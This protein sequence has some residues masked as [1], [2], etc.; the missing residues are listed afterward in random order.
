MIGLLGTVVGMIQAFSRI[1]MG[2]GAPDPNQLVG[3]IAIALV[4]TFWGL[5]VAIPGLTAFAFFRNRIDAYAA[6]CIRL[7]DRVVELAAASATSKDAV[8]K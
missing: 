3:D 2:G 5:F 7:C 8:G 6:E 4:N 1:H